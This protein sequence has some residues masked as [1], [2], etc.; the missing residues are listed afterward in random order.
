MAKINLDLKG[1]HCKS[2]KMV[3]EDV[4]GDLG[5]TDVQV[6]VD[7]KNQTGKVSCEFDDKKKVIEAIQKEGY[8]VV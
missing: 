4:L 3:I 8:R 7:E 2:C 6:T 5:A 1:T